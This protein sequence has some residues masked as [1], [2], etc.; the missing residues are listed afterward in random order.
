MITYDKIT[1]IFWIA[2]EFCQDF[3][4][5]TQNFILGKRSRL[6]A[7]MSNISLI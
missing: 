1:N 5:T 7:T 2:D 3:E 6:P 4:K